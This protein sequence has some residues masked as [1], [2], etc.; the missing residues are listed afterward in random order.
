MFVWAELPAPLDATALLPA[1]VAAG[2]AFVP[3][4]A[5]YAEAPNA[6]TLRLSYATV[7]PADIVT[8]MARLGRVIAAALRFP[9]MSRALPPPT[10]RHAA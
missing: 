9:P 3:G 6:G 7:A 2:V 4:T 8:G 5:F 10:A 1:A